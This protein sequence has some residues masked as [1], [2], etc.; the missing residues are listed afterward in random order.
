[1][2]AQPGL[3]VGLCGL[4]ECAD[5]TARIVALVR[6][7]REGL[8]Q[9]LRNSDRAVLAVSGGRS[10]IGLFEALSEE[11]LPWQRVLLTLV[12]ERLVPLS[13]P[14]SNEALVRCHL[15]RGAAAQ[16][17][18]LGLVQ[19]TPP[20]LPGCVQVAN[21]RV[22]PPSVALLGMGEDGHTASLFA[23]AQGIEDAMDVARAP[24][25]VGVVPRAAPHARISLSLRALLRAPVLLLSIEGQAK[26]K[27]FE[28]A[29]SEPG[30]T[31][32]IARLLHHRA[33]AL[34]TWW[35]P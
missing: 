28:A 11:D 33:C 8:E 23:D 3:P 34:Q 22:P 7:V 17:S 15:L 35:S 19:G 26:R 30:S 27:T 16:A 1:M 18:M 6:A 31:A 2:N 20:V 21:Q 32:P 4:R 9:A 13:H 29:C 12:D 5:S 25:Y 24:L 10:P 14:D